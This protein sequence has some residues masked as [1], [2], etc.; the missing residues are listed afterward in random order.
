MADMTKATRDG[1]GEEILNLGKDNKD[2][3]V[4]DV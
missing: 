1:F 3:Y 4:I 2:I